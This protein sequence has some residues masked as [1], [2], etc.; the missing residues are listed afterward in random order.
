MDP[1]LCFGPGTESIAPTIAAI[2]ARSAALGLALCVEERSWT[3]AATDP[4]VVRR[5]VD[6]S[7]FEPLM[8]IADLP[9]PSARDLKARFMPARSELDKT[10][11]RLLGALHLRRAEL[12]VADDGRL[13]RLA[14]RAGLGARVIT[15][16]DTLAWLDSLA[17][18]SRELLV[19]EA[20]LPAVLADP[21]LARMLAEDC[22]PFDPYLRARLEAAG[23]RRLVVSEG[24]VIV[25]MG[26]LVPEAGALTL[27]ALAS[28]DTARGQRALEPIVAAALTSARRLR[29][30]LTA[31]V[32]LHQDHAL[33][34]RDQLGFER[35]GRDRHGREIF[36][37]ALDDAAVR[38]ATAERAWLLPLDAA[39]HGS[40]VRRQLLRTSSA[41]EPADGDLLLLYQQRAADRNRS[42]SITAA[43]RVTRVQQA[44]DFPELLALTAG[45]D[46]ASMTRQREMLDAGTVSVMDLHWLG[47]L[48]RPLALS[49]LIERGII[50]SKPTD[51]LCLAPD[52]LHRLAPELVLA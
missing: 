43:A 5:G 16:W 14:K 10:D 11:L 13:H 45:R 35:R 6:L 32:P 9:L 22:E 4:D 23:S 17:G 15:P 34:L 8:R 27:A 28:A 41:N 39:S 26:L 51:A 50:A 44:R 25:A 2:A 49:S 7:R 18:R 30:G 3:E 1:Y 33:L 46:G 20:G 36:C 37:H 38:P 42:T 48:A 29:I 21:A 47:T 52:A 24:S 40:P 12:L 19:A 31:L